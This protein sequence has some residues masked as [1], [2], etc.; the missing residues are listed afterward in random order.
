M[1]RLQFGGVPLKPLGQTL[2]GTTIRLQFGGV[3]SKPLGHC[4]GGVTPRLHRSPSQA[5]PDGQHFPGTGVGDQPC[6]HAGGGVVSPGAQ[7]VCP[8][9]SNG[10]NLTSTVAL[11]SP[12]LVFC[13]PPLAGFKISTS[14]S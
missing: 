4:S 2:G 14:F 12:S 7:N 9:F 13:G 11:S 10:A 1:I 8:C 5:L 3:P 6:G